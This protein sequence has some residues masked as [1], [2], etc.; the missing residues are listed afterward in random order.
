MLLG[1]RTER[2]ALGHPEMLLV[3]ARDLLVD[4]RPD[5]AKTAA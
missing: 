4:R 5:H 1:R 3:L 2:A